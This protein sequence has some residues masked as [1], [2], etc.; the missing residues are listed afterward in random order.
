MQETQNTKI[1]QAAYAAF[2]RGDIPG[3]LNLLAD[4]V[5]WQGV[6]GAAAHVPMAGKR[7]GKASVDEFF[8][9][10]SAH[11]TFATF[12]PREYAAHAV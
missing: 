9:L 3:I 7:R 5:I 2:G 8:K 12:E 10:V 4:N 1:V 11:E 6:Y